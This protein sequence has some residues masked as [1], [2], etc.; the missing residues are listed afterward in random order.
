[1]LLFHSSYNTLFNGT[2]M[3]IALATFPFP[4]HIFNHS[5]KSQYPAVNLI[6]AKHLP[7]HFMSSG[8]REPVS[9]SGGPV[10]IWWWDD[11]SGCH[12]CLWII[13]AAQQNNNKTDEITRI[14]HN[15]TPFLS[16]KMVIYYTIKIGYIKK[17]VSKMWDNCCVNRRTS[18]GKNVLRNAHVLVSL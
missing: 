10:M 14:K 12:V 6:A 11:I 3:I 7:W 8:D 13:P 2:M 17:N 1:M 5:W 9:I 16:I 15:L 18:P 4:D